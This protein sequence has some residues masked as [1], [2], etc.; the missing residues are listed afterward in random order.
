MKMKNWFQKCLIGIL[1]AA[2]CL[3]VVPVDTFAA[4]KSSLPALHVE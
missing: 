1:I 2:L 4:T 3:T